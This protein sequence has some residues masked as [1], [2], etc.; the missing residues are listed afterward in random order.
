[1]GTGDSAGTAE[2]L[3]LGAWANR[4]EIEAGVRIGSQSQPGPPDR[5]FDEFTKRLHTG[6]YAKGDG[7]GRRHRETDYGTNRTA[8]GESATGAQERFRT[9]RSIRQSGMENSEGRPA[10]AAGGAG[11]RCG[12]DDR[13]CAG[14]RPN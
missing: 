6:G 4:A 11:K 9:E 14:N 2:S 3:P 8:V 13:G 5:P 10:A 7:P 12:R 1:M